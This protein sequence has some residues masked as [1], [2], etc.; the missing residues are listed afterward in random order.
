MDCSGS[1]SSCFLT[2]WLGCCFR[3]SIWVEFC[4][5]DASTGGGHHPS[6]G[7]TPLTLPSSFQLLTRTNYLRWRSV[8]YWYLFHC[9]PT[10]GFSHW[11][12]KCLVVVLANLRMITRTYNIFIVCAPPCITPP[13]VNTLFW[14]HFNSISIFLFCSSGSPCI[15]LMGDDQFSGSVVTP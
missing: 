7:L 12:I 9:V 14:H 4:Y 6:T 11:Q 8:L 15:S 10:T 3:L 2:L 1:G 5:I 13:I